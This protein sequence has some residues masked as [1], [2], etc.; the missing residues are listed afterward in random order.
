MFHKRLNSLHPA[1]RFTVEGEEDGSLPFLEVKITKTE[2]HVNLPETYLQR[3]L[4]TLGFVQSDHLQA[5][6]RART[7]E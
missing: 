4:Y 6:P 5:Q 3:T 1:L 2:A 7:D